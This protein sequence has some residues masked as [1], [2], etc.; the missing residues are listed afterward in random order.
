MP[1]NHLQIGFLNRDRRAFARDRD[2]PPA[3]RKNE[4]GENQNQEKG[5]FSHISPLFEQLIDYAHCLQGRPINCPHGPI[6]HQ[7]PAIDQVGRRM[8]PDPEETF[9]LP[10][11]VDKHRHVQ[12]FLLQ[13]IL[14]RFRLFF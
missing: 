12:R 3:T 14:D 7:G 8:D 10:G 13:E 2:H 11:F 6:A 5:F 9:R 1:Q 4:K